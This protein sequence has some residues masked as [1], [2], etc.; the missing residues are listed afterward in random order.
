MTVMMP[1]YFTDFQL[2]QFARPEFLWLL[3]ALPLL[4]LRLHDRRLAL[5]LGRTVIV[6]LMIIALADPRTVS[7]QTSFDERLFAFDVSRSIA[8]GMRS[9]MERY[10]QGE[11]APGSNDRVLLFG[12]EAAD[13][14][15]WREVL[16]GEA[17]A[18]VDAKETN[19]EK[20]LTTLLALPPRPRTLFLFTDG[21]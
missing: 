8:P 13:S 20:L 4:W 18:A 12:A 2:T 6:A 14:N 3:A 21:W 9:W 10:A 15:N 1:G 7:Q 19:L 11:S 17:N 16:K 5:I